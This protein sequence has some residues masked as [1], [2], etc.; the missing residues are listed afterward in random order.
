MEKLADR[1]DVRGLTTKRQQSVTAVIPDFILL[2]GDDEMEINICFTKIIDI[3]DRIIIIL[4]LI[5][6]LRKM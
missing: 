2:K 5:I 1:M 6:L 4:V 3:L